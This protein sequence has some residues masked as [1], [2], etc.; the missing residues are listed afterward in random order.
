M[1]DKYFD[2]IVISNSHMIDCRCN[3]ILIIIK[4]LSCYVY[5]YTDAWLHL[6][7]TSSIG[8]QGGGAGAHERQGRS[9]KLPRI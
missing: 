7:K 4:T 3:I 2:I 5:M 8:L 9:G 1:Y 6:L